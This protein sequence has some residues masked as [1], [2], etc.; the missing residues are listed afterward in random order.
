MQAAEHEKNDFVMNSMLYG[1]P[2]EG[3]YTGMISS[4]LG[5]K[6]TKCMGH[7]QCDHVFNVTDVRHVILRD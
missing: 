2:V 7:I 1:Q 5:R 3:N 4:R 6:E